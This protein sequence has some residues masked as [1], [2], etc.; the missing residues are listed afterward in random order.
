L[1]D[2]SPLNKVYIF[3]ISLLGEKNT[4]SVSKVLFAVGA[5]AV[6]V[7]LVPHWLTCGTHSNKLCSE[8][9]A[10]IPFSKQL[11]MLCFA[12][13]VLCFLALLLSSSLWYYRNTKCESCRKDWAYERIEDPKT[14]A[15]KKQAKHK[16]VC[17]FC[18]HVKGRK[19]KES[20]A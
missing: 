18:G 20:Q 5:C 4:E 1:A 6:V 9:E 13:A 14:Q 17:K 16:F 10:Q 3:I 2:Y 11:T 12:G 19:I 7:G 8:R 15:E